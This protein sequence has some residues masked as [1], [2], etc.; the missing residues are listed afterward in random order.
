MR[1]ALSF[2]NHRRCPLICRAP[3]IRPLRGHLLPP[4]EKGT[5]VHTS[6]ALLASLKNMPQ[7]PPSP[8]VGE[9]LGM[10][11]ALS[12]RHGKSRERRAYLAPGQARGDT[13]GVRPGTAPS[14][15]LSTLH[16]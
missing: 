3:L 2:T 12:L 15:I 10:R 5:G 7:E 1:G 16:R 14:P 8:L 9:G 11:G 13:V 4:G 6:I